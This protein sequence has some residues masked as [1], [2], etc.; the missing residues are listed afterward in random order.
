MFEHSLILM[1]AINE[2]MMQIYSISQELDYEIKTIVI[3]FEKRSG[4][5]EDKDADKYPLI[6]KLI[7]LVDCMLSGNKDIAIVT[8]VY[9]DLWKPAKLEKLL[10]DSEITKFVYDNS[11]KIMI[12]KHLQPIIHRVKVLESFVKESEYLNKCLDMEE[13]DSNKTSQ[14]FS[15]LF[16]K[17][18]KA[19]IDWK[20]LYDSLREVIKNPSAK[21]SETVRKRVR[22]NQKESETEKES[23][24][25]ILKVRRREKD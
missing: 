3:L 15:N 5:T 1:T 7:D 4:T 20:S 8:M 14:F 9:Q 19:T 23:Q 25:E 11:A 24:K 6:D 17:P 12:T 18:I 10:N 16:G 22:Q 21:E 2:I 13:F